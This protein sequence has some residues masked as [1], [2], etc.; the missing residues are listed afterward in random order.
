MNEIMT[1]GSFIQEFGIAVFLII[2]MVVSI[3]VL[4]KWILKYFEKQQ[5]L[6]E[7]AQ[8]GFME[9]LTENR[10]VNEGF[11][12]RLGS[13]ERGVEDLKSENKLAHSYQ[14]QE[15]EAVLTSVKAIKV[16]G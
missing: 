12:T 2:T 1:L 11:I 8:K 5:N 16:R 13:L 7:A 4:A 6:Y 10:K 3:F 9:F 14:R 15:H